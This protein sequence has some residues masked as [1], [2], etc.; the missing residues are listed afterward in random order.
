MCRG[1]SIL[2]LQGYVRPPTRFVDNG[3][4]TICDNQT[5]LMWEKKD[6]ADGV[7]DLSNPHD[8]DNQYSWTIM[9]DGD[10]TNPDGKAFTDFLARLNGDVTS[11]PNM[12]GVGFAGYMD[13]RLPNA[14]ELQALL[15]EPAPCSI[16]P[17]IIDPAFA[18]TYENNGFYWSS[19]SHI[20]SANVWAVRFVDGYMTAIHKGTDEPVHAVRGGR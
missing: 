5:G 16:S 12:A 17:C 10:V 14:V 11:D 7:E 8:V 6:A 15:F 4:G 9:A 2:G 20:L 3:D 19:T 1:I 13:W 18:P